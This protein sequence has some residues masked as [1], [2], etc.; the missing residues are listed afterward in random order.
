[1]IIPTCGHPVSEIE[2][3]H[4]LIIGEYSLNHE[5]YVPCIARRSYCKDCY[6]KALQDEDCPVLLTSEDDLAWFEG[7]HPFQIKNQHGG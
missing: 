7:V 2:D 6:E 1:M 4:T 5:G 3:V